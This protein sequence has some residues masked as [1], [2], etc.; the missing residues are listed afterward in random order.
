MIDAVVADIVQNIVIV[1]MD[2]IPKRD[3]QA[4]TV[5]IQIFQIGTTIITGEIDIVEIDIAEADL[6]IIAAGVK[7]MT[8]TET[9]LVKENDVTMITI[10]IGAARGVAVEAEKGGERVGV[11]ERIDLAGI[12]LGIGLGIDLGTDLGTDLGIDMKRRERD[13]G[14]DTEIDLDQRKGPMKDRGINLARET[15]IV[16][17]QAID[18]EAE[19]DR[20]IGETGIVKTT[21]LVDAAAKA[22]ILGIVTAQMKER[23]QTEVSARKLQIQA[24]D[25]MNGILNLG[26]VG[27][28]VEVEKE[29]EKVG[30]RNVVE[31]G[32]DL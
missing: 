3:R 18:L 12:G 20:E 1:K 7:E 15:G 25:L 23:H 8:I 27:A 29:V 32:V 5:I 14:T 16:V 9:I 21:G 24:M 30:K 31:V 22:L 2:G 6:L 10:T 26:D 11:I 4:D 28:E 19:K 13:L 17:D